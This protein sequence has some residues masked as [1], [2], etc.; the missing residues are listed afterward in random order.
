MGQGG[1]VKTMKAMVSRG[2]LWS[3]SDMHARMVEDV[4]YMMQ[5]GA[6]GGTAALTPQVPDLRNSITKR[7]KMLVGHKREHT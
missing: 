3:Q 5:G 6:G 7:E 2:G 1:K 4:D